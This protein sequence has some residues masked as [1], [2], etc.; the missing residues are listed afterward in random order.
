MNAETLLSHLRGAW[1]SLTVWFAML[2]AAAPD[3]LAMIQANFPTIAPF[4]PQSLQSR[5][6]QIIALVVLLLRLKTNASLAAK[7]TKPQ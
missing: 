2:L 1:K 6:V 4:I 7:G 5:S 3:A